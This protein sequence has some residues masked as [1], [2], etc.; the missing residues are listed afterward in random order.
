MAIRNVFKGL[1]FIALLTVSATVLSACSMPD[2]V[3]DYLQD[4]GILDPDEYKD[5]QSYSEAITAGT[6]DSASGIS[7]EVID[8]YQ[9]DD[10]SILGSS[11][12]AATAAT[13]EIDEDNSKNLD[14]TENE[15]SNL[16]TSFDGL[17]AY[18]HLDDEGKVLYAEIYTILTNLDSEVVVS[19][20]D[21]DEMSVVFNYVMMDHPEIF[22]VTGYTYAE[23]TLGDE[24]QKLT[25]T[26]TYTYD[27]DEIALRQSK[28][29]LYVTAALAGLPEGADEYTKVKYVYEY[30]IN[31]TDYVAGSADNQNICSVFM[32]NKSVCQGYA[33]ATQYLLQKMGVECTLVTGTVTDSDGNRGGH[34]W[35]LVKID[36]E[37]YYVD[38]TWGD[39]SYQTSSVDLDE[40]QRIP[41]INYFYLNVTTEEL[42]KTHRISNDIEMPECTSMVANYYVK[43]Q[44]YF[45][46]CNTDALKALFDRRLSDGSNNVTIKCSSSDVYQQIYDLLVTDRGVFDYI[47]GEDHTV[48]YTMF[49]SQNT[50]IFWL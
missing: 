20:K 18:E 48:S 50:M 9:F 33:K 13:Q 17:Y 5:S 1:R 37:Y 19:T 26:G 16:A 15:L 2:A 10:S 47:S 28:I 34:A 25:F 21:K 41:T 40:N 12:E 49:K 23:Y 3:E 39:A 32:Y 42:T 44:E 30:I 7:I 4:L 45:D 14:L 8:S 43:E 24:V 6:D 35:N 46:S 22:Y 11:A 31:S 29:D 36:G 38:T 27:E